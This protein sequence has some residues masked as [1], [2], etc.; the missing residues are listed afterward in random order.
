MAI[1]VTMPQMGE[2]VVEGTL[3]RWLVREGERVEKDQVLCEIT[4]DKVDAE[5]VAPEA[6]VVTR[7]AVAQGQTV[8]VGAELALLEPSGG[9]AA[10]SAVAGVL[11][12]RPVG[13]CLDMPPIRASTGEASPPPS[14]WA[15][16]A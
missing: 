15:H 10:R 7:L 3:E 6:G 12:R 11:V 8:P 2:S 14:P 13:G 1:S 4:T 16:R 9:A 5:V